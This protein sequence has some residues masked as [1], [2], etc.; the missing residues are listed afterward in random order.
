M[1][2][3]TLLFFILTAVMSSVQ[4]FALVTNG[5]PQRIHKTILFTE[6]YPLHIHEFIP[7]A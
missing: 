3:L 4:R 7:Q 2:A 1:V 5:Q 6:A